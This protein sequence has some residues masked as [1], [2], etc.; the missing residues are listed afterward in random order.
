MATTTRAKKA[1]PPSKSMV[2]SVLRSIVSNEAIDPEKDAALIAATIKI[3]EQLDR[4]LVVAEASSP[5]D[6][7]YVATQTFVAKALYMLPHLQS[8]L[9]EMLATPASRAA[10]E[11]ARAKLEK[12]STAQQRGSGRG[13]AKLA[14]LRAANSSAA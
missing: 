12:A 11:V 5:L 6:E 2:E 14:S 1:V 13:A 8:N 7:G 9:K 4:V 3:A 10:V